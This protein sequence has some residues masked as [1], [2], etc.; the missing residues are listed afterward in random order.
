MDKIL[1][2]DGV[3][4]MG[5]YDHMDLGETWTQMNPNWE[6]QNCPSWDSYNFGAP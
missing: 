5:W 2:M 6:F 3:D 4:S 1:H